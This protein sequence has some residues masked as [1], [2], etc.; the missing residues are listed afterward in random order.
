MIKRVL[1]PLDP[2]PY[3]DAALAFACELARKHDAAI[4]GLVILDTCGIE[5]SIG[6][7]PAGGLYYADLHIAR[8]EK[9]SHDRIRA[10]LE[11]FE[12]HCESAKVRHFQSERQ[13]TPAENIVQE[14]VFYDC[15][16]IGL[17]TFFEYETDAGADLLYGTSD[18]HP[19]DSLDRVTQHSV[20]PTFAIP[21]GWKPLDRPF[22]VLLAFNGSVASVRSLHQFANLFTPATAEVTVLTACPDSIKGRFLLDQVEAYLNAHGFEKIRKEWTGMDIRRAMSNGF[23]ERS[24]LIVVGAHSKTLIVDFMLGS[25]CKDLIARA[26][27]PLLIAH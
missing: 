14:S 11:K 17:R 13:G 24:D 22:K 23:A 5:K 16:T 6:P 18:D 15:V 7:I 4:G 12:A 27:K 19:G 20:V 9:Q 25:V 21:L 8:E 2:S 3:A 26:E 10:L 1:I